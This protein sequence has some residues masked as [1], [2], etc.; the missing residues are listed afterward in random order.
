LQSTPDAIG[1]EGDVTSGDSEKMGTGANFP[2]MAQTSIGRES[3]HHRHAEIRSRPHFLD[4]P[5][6]GS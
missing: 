2:S 6:A 3:H 1:G 4:E 5:F